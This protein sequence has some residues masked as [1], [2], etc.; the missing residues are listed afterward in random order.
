MTQTTTTRHVPSKSVLTLA[1]RVGSEWQTNA[2][3]FAGYKID[4]TAFDTAKAT[5]ES[6]VADAER[7]KLN[8]ADERARAETTYRT[9]IEHA[10]AAR[11]AAIAAATTAHADALEARDTALL[12]LSRYANGARYYAKGIALSDEDAGNDNAGKTL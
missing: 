6:A 12:T 7:A 11:A 4:K 2:P 1:T 9:T 8:L 5:A 10:K 3:L